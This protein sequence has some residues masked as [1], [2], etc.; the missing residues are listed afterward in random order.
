[1]I[2]EFILIVDNYKLMYRF[3]SIR[4]THSMD[5]LAGQISV[6]TSREDPNNPFANFIFLGASY[7]AIINTEIVS[8]GYIDD[9]PVNYSGT[10]EQIEFVGIDKT[11][12]LI[13]CCYIADNVTT[14]GVSSLQNLSILAIVK[15]LCSPFNVSVSVDPSCIKEASTIIRQY[16]VNFGQKVI[17]LITKLC[18]DYNIM[19]ISTGD[20][21][22]TLTKTGTKT[23]PS[24]LTPS[25]VKS[26]K[27]NQSNR[28]RYSAYLVIGQGNSD[29]NKTVKENNSPKS[30][31]Y[32]DPVISKIPRYRP[33][34]IF[35]ENA[36][37]QG[38]CQ[39]RAVM[40]ANYRAGQSRS[41]EY[42]VE[43]WTIPTINTPWK[44]N[45]L[46]FVEDPKFYIFRPLLIS[47][48][49]FNYD[50]GSGFTTTLK[51]VHP[52]TYN[53]TNDI[54]LMN[55]YFDK[56]NQINKKGSSVQ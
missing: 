52:S 38:I 7:T 56:I 24:I 14:P 29:D 8:T 6:R 41:V 36:T 51:L 40:E 25:L 26:G 18:L 39:A 33:L 9:I 1:M 3:E 55:S 49:S 48:V 17:E 15:K 13:E 53:T 44:I 32:I 47:E 28:N 19:P 22:L 45:Q 20:G 12:D 54:E 34:V 11:V 5:S 30:G 46:I 23:V 4:V 16:D 35:Q 27:I 43:G 31:L 21:N 2:N 10:D 50:D 42:V 37:A